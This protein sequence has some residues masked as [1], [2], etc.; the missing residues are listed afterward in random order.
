MHEMI[1]E[2][3]AQY[4]LLRKSITKEIIRNKKE[5]E[6][7]MEYELQCI[8]SSYDSRLQKLSQQYQDCLKHLIIKRDNEN[9]F[10]EQANKMKKIIAQLKLFSE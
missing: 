6:R 10:I 5:T 8:K 2:N 7:K 1:K 3:D 4:I 9:E